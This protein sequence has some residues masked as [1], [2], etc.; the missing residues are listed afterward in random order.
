MNVAEIETKP[1]KR[2]KCW[3]VELR[4]D[5]CK[6]CYLCIEVCPIEGIFSRSEEIGERGFQVVTVDPE[7]C[8]GCMLCELLCP[9]LA[10]TI[11]E[12]TERNE[13]L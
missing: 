11:E 3:K 2:T 4:Q 10:I 9:D 6:G 12:L 7:N 8:T 13:K 5:W 1:K